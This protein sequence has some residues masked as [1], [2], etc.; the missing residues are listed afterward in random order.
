MRVALLVLA[1]GCG[2]VGF[3]PNGDAQTTADTR[4]D[5]RPAMVLPGLVVRYP[6]DDDP[7]G[8]VVASP[9]LPAACTVCPAPTAGVLDGAYVFDGAS[10]FFVVPSTTLV[11]AA[12]YSVAVWLRV[13]RPALPLVGFS[14][15]SKPLGPASNFNAVNL[16]VLDSL[17]LTQETTTDGVQPSYNT[18]PASIGLGEWHHVVA[19]WDGVN[20]RIYQDGSLRQLQPMVTALDSAEQIQVGADRDSDVL[21]YFFAGALDELQYYGRALD[22]SEISLLAVR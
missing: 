17:Q 12:P 9:Q 5:S 13:D 18:V 4:V 7:R 14:I 8:G 15:T 3:E 20:K 10:M 11:G 19:T 22:E 1:A 21:N 2:R 16:L 6:M